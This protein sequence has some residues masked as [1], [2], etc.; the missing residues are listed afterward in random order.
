MIW[1]R[2]WF[3]VFWMEF[4]QP[5]DWPGWNRGPY[6]SAEFNRSTARVSSLVADPVIEVRTAGPDHAT[7]RDPPSGVNGWSRNIPSGVSV[8]SRDIP[9]DVNVG[10]RDTASGANGGNRDIPSGVNGGNRDTASGANG[11]N[12]CMPFKIWSS[13]MVHHW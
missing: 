12:R 2:I 5:R 4:M 8:G 6:H 1:S 13:T 11:G 7:D 3:H 9:S 10:N